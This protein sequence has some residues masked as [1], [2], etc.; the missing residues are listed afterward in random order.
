MW[1]EHNPQNVFSLNLIINKNIWTKHESFA[2]LVDHL[3]NSFREVIHLYL[4]FLLKRN[5]SFSYKA[6]QVRKWSWKW[7]VSA[8]GVWVGVKSCRNV[9]WSQR[10]RSRLNGHQA[11]LTTGEQG[12]LKRQGDRIWH[13]VPSGCKMSFKCIF[14]CFFFFF[15]QKHWHAYIQNKKVARKTIMLCMHV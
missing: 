13:G 1:Q 10:K 11:D 3:H 9:M 7:L 5:P 12:R 14:C 4:L 15:C 2:L 8:A 6:T